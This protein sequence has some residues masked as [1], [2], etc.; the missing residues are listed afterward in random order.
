MFKKTSDDTYAFSGRFW[1]YVVI[2]SMFIV[3]IGWRTQET[4][5]RVEDQVRYNTQF[6]E[7][8]NKCLAEVVGV[9][10]TRATYND[11]IAELDARRQAIWEKLVDDLAAAN[12]SDGLNLQALEAFRRANSQLR[13]DQA[14]VTKERDKNQYPR[15][16][17]IE[18]HE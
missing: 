4:S 15:C 17:Q 11:E 18:E 14:Q 2:A 3:W 5:N 7:E 13:I 1:T 12:N 9:I 10:K 16:V 6:A 8:T